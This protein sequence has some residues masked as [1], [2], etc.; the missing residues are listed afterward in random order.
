MNSNA[1]NAALWLNSHLH[2]IRI[3]RFGAVTVKHLWKSN[4]QAQVLFS[5][6]MDGAKPRNEM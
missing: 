3:T 6:V 5:K 4:F 2:F 1:L